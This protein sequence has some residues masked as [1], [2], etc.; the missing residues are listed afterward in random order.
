MKQEYYLIII[1]VLLLYIIIDKLFRRKGSDTKDI[2]NIIRKEVSTLR[3][4]NDNIARLNRQEI[5]DQLL[6]NQQAFAMQYNELTRLNEQKLDNIRATLRASIMEMNHENSVQLERMRNVV[7]E[8]LQNT[9]EKRLGDSFSLVNDRLEQVYKGLGEMQNIAAGV[10]DLKRVLQNIRTRGLWGEAQLEQLLEQV[11]VPSQYET[12][13]AVK[14]NSSER[15]E[16]AII[17]PGKDDKVYLPIDCKFPQEDYL[18]LVTA[19]ENGDK[20][21]IQLAL[22][23]LETSIK[24]EAKDISTKYIAPPYTTDFAI[25]YLP[26]E[27]LYAEVLRNCTLFDELQKMRVLV[28]GPTTFAAILNSLNV[29]FKTLAIEKRSS[30]VWQLLGGVK[31]EFEKFALLLEKTQKKLQEA[32]NV[33]SDAARKTRTIGRKLKEVESLPSQDVFNSEEDEYDNY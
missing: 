10:G 3:Q 5:S 21:Q 32:N 8:K 22:K 25:M 24:K 9:L 26:V 29:G 4:D 15:V 14:P 1:G 28:T 23:Q 7:D 19:S 16:F 33:I 30:E 2:E 12:N 11:L 13:V 31:T 27:G 18:R 6:K 17:L 20:E